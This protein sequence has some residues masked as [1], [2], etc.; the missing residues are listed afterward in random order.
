MAKMIFHLPG[1]LQVERE[2]PEASTS[3]VSAPSEKPILE[4]TA[5]V[6]EEV[7]KPKARRGRPKKK[8]DAA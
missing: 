7:E 4:K 3:E 6:L 1:G 8:P 2:V 5:E